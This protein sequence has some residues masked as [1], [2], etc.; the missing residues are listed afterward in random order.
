[1]LLL[2]GSVFLLAPASVEALATDTPATYYVLTFLSELRIWEYRL[3]EF[4]LLFF[5]AIYLTVIVRKHRL[6]TEYLL[7]PGAMYLLVAS[8]IPPF[9]GISSILLANTFILIAFDQLMST[10]R[11]PKAAGN[12]FDTGLWIA[13]A[14]LFYFPYLFF[15]LLAIFGLSS[16]RAFKLNEF[17]SMLFGAITVFFLAATIT[18]WND[19]LSYFLEQQFVVNSNLL[20][21]SLSQRD[22][23]LVELLLMAFLLLMVLFGYSS[24]ML[25]QNIQFQKKVGILYIMLAISPFALVLQPSLSV[26]H[27]GILIVPIGVLLGL[28]LSNIGKTTAELLH[29]ILLVLVL[30]WQLNPYWLSSG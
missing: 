2:R 27:L 5:H 25:K 3:V 22:F 7:L 16:L 23:F 8:A 14:S 21:L 9:L 4:L 20:N 11:K 19:H 1:M 15:L 17:F 18:F 29:F 26:S 12:I 30:A 6:V 10:Y 24:I 28:L 13:I